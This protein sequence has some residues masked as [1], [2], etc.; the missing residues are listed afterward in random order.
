MKYQILEGFMISVLETKVTEAI[1]KGWKPQ[2][3]LVILSTLT[4]QRFYQTMVLERDY[5]SGVMG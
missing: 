5:F 1:S 4:D 3:G 2:G